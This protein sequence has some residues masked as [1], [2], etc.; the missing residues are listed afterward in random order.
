MITDNNPFCF[1]YTA[2]KF[3]EVLE[4]FRYGGKENW[5]L[6]W[7]EKSL[8]RGVFLF[9]RAFSK[10]GFSPEEAVFIDDL[11]ANIEGAKKAGFDEDACFLYEPY[12]QESN[13]QFSKFLNKHFPAKK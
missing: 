2:F 9:H 12:T 6:S 3:P 8:K 11:P 13:I 5:I 10:F 1:D 4:L 7:E